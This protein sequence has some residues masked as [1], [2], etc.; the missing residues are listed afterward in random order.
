MAESRGVR[1]F[2][3]R[4]VIRGTLTLLGCGPS[5]RS[6]NKKDGSTLLEP[7]FCVDYNLSHLLRSDNQESAEVTGRPPPF[8]VIPLPH[9]HHRFIDTKEAPPVHRHKRGETSAS[10][11]PPSSLTS[12]RPEEKGDSIH[13]STTSADGGL[14]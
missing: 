4:A 9:R 12:W 10:P 8:T 7:R 11:S 5:L 13:P 2:P 6:A 1:D 14:F 3:V